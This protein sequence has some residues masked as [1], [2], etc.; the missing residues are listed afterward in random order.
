QVQDGLLAGWHDDARAAQQIQRQKRGHLEAL[1]RRLLLDLEG[2]EAELLSR[3]GGWPQ[4]VGDHRVDPGGGVLVEVTSTIF[5]DGSPLLSSAKAEDP[6]NAGVGYIS[7][8]GDYWMPAFA[9]MTVEMEIT[10]Q[11]TLLVHRQILD[12]RV[13]ARERVG[14]IPGIAQRLE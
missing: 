14:R 7:D 13:L 8:A 9:G 10:C 11:P 1:A 6:V 4:Q 3:A 12:R 2:I 5:T